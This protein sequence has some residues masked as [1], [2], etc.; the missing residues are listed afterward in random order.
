MSPVMTAFV[1]LREIRTEMWPGVCPGVGS[2]QTSSVIRSRRRR[3]RPARRIDR[4]HRVVDA[5]L[6]ERRLP[7]FE[8]KSH[9]V[10]RTRYLALGNVGTH[11]PFT[12]IVFQPT[13]STCRCVQITVSIDFAREARARSERSRNG[14]VEVVPLRDR[15]RLVVADAGVDDDR[16]CPAIRG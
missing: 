9:S 12:S 7:V 3:A 8:K 15:A 11:L 10:P 2:S 4:P 13:W 6:Q 14:A 16:A 5:T 1:A